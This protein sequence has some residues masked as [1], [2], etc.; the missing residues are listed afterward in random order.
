MSSPLSCASSP[1]STALLLLGFGYSYAE[2]MDRQNWSCR[3]VARCVVE[4]R[5]ALRALTQD[6]DR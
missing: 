4:G 1:T 2:I 5:G 6:V 3:K